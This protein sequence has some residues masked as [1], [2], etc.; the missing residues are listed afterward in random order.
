[1]RYEVSAQI[2]V[3]YIKR[4]IG[5]PYKWGGDD[6]MEGFDCSGLA[7]EMLK[8]VGHMENDSDDTADGLMRRFQKVEKPVVGCLAFFGRQERATHVGICL[9]AVEMLEAGG[10]GSKTNDLDDAKEQ[11]AFIRMRP[12]S[13]RKDFICF[14]DPFSGEP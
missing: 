5:L 10:G 4:F 8:S 14:N 3:E 12:I 1:V 2:A 9:N 6:P 7:N 11:N 13:N